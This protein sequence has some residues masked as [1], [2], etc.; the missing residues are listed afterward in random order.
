MPVTIDEFLKD[1]PDLTRLREEL[2][3]RLASGDLSKSGRGRRGDRQGHEL[4]RGC[5]LRAELARQESLLRERWSQGR[6]GGLTAD[7]G[8][9]VAHQLSA[10]AASAGVTAHATVEADEQG[11]WIVFHGSLSP[12]SS[13][14]RLWLK[15]SSPIRVRAHWEGFT[16]ACARAAASV[17]AE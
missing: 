15:A 17:A 16:P 9:I 3:L 12:R 10:E 4:A 7:E 8:R 11:D 13:T 2:D 1:H 14:H 6:E 5:R